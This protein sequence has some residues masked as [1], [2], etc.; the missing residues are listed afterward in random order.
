MQEQAT[1]YVGQASRR[2]P[3]PRSAFRIPPAELNGV[4]ANET[5][6]TAFCGWGQSVAPAQSSQTAKLSG[7][8]GTVAAT[9]SAFRV[10]CS[11][12]RIPFPDLFQYPKESVLRSC[13]LSAIGY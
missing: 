7:L 1:D 9:N 8:G 2:L 12:F 11:A 3:I 13:R 4:V 6:A 5:M 10:L